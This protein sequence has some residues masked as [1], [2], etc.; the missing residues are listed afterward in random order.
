[1]GEEKKVKGLFEV[2]NAR[3]VYKNFSGKKT[4][5]NDEGNRNFGVLISDE[6]AKRLKDDGWNVKYMK[7]REDDPDQYRQP[8]LPVKVKF[9]DYPPIVYIVLPNKGNPRKI[10][11]DESTIGQLDWSYVESCDMQ[12]RPY[13]YPARQGRPAGVAAYLKCLYATI[14]QD[15]LEMKYGSIPEIGDMEEE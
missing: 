5:F 14:R 1:M 11:L 15:D 4:E 6:D 3:I 13:N 7:P 2:E 9:G 8:W 12:I 10:K